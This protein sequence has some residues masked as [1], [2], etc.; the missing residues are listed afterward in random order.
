MDEWLLITFKRVNYL[1][2]LNGMYILVI[3][4]PIRHKNLL[5]GRITVEKKGLASRKAFVVF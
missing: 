1:A 3:R 5:V 4:Y 2:I